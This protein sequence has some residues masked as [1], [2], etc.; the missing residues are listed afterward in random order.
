MRFFLKLNVFLFQS[1][2]NLLCRVKCVVL[3]A[4]DKVTAQAFRLFGLGDQGIWICPP[5]G[6]ADKTAYRDRSTQRGLE[7][8]AAA[9]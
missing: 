7:R 5:G 4:G 9:L 2:L 8:H 1:I 6:D 3:F